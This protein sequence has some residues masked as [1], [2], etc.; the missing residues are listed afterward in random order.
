MAWVA[1][2]LGLFAFGGFALLIWRA[3]QIAR[4]WLAQHAKAVDVQ[5]SVAAPPP[6]KPALPLD[7]ELIAAQETEAWAQ[8]QV[9]G[10]MQDVYEAQGNWDD[11]RSAYLGAR[12]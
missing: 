2:W 10:A 5:A 8:E 7:L 1:F 4:T 12:E 3:E 6:K 11:V 9:R